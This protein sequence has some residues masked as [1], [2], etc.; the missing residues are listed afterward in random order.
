MPEKSGLE[1]IS[2]AQPLVDKN[3][4]LEFII[5][6]GHG[7]GKEA[8]DGLKLGAI[9]FLEKPIDLSHLVQVILRAEELVFLKRTSRRYEASLETDVDAKTQIIEKRLI[10]LDSPS[11]VS[12]ENLADTVKY[13]DSGKDNHIRRVREYLHVITK[14]LGWVKRSSKRYVAGGTIA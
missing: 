8:I 14:E 4:D 3:R 12:F 11:K 1:L 5:L 10:N 13:K 9:A 7:G 6:T 2:G